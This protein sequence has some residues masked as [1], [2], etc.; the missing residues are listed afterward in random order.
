MKSASA[1]RHSYSADFSDTPGISDHHCDATVHSSA[2]CVALHTPKRPSRKAFPVTRA[3][4]RYHGP[5]GARH[6]IR[7]LLFPSCELADIVVCESSS[8][9][10]KDQIGIRMSGD[11]PRTMC[12]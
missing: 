2:T 12:L 7:E 4:E 6:K 11:V 10:V 5:N 9:I 3:V 1:G 8:R